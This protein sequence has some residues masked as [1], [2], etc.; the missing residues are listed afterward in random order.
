VFNVL[1]A[2]RRGS[3]GFHRFLDSLTSS[4]PPTAI[5]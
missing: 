2:E 5:G 4:T 1:T 3:P